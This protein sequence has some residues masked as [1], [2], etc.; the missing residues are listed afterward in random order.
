[1]RHIQGVM[2]SVLDAPAL[3]FKLQPLRLIE[4]GLGA[5][6]DLPGLMEFALGANLA[7]DAGDLH[8]SGQPQFLGFNG[9]GDNRPIFLA[10]APIAG[11]L[12]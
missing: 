7:I 10:S 9:P 5:A 4:L 1:M 3:L 6:S 8:R 2:G 11:L 12:Q